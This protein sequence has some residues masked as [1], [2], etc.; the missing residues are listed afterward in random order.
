M[1]GLKKKKRCGIYI[2][3]HTQW[4]TTQHIK[5]QNSEMCSNMMQLV[6]IIL[7]ELGQKEKDKHSMIP[8]MCGI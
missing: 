1:N 7:T 4:N 2:Y 6:I 8:L 3:I 5:R